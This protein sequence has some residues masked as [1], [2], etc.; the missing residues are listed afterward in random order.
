MGRLIGVP[1]FLTEAAIEEEKNDNATARKARK[2][3]D[4]GLSLRTCQVEAVRRMQ[5]Q[6]CGAVLRRTTDSRNWKGLTL[7]NLP[8]H[9]EIMGI[10]TL[11]ERET[12]IIAERAEV[13]KERYVLYIIL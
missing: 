6:F 3:D 1:H 13:A 11:T 7:L 5:K 2:L 10:L 8:P 4:D 12:E 9:R